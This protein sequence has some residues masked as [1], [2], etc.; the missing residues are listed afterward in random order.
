VYKMVELYI[1]LKNGN[2]KSF[3]FKSLEEATKIK[4][5][6]NGLG[7]TIIYIRTI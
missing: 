6:L 5:K 4:E 3:I 2:R 7:Y 1:E